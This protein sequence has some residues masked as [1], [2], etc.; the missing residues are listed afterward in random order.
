MAAS[1]LLFFII[2]Q[3]CSSDEREEV[4]VEEIIGREGRSDAPVWRVRRPVE[5]R[6]LKRDGP[7]PDTTLAIQEWIIG[8]GEDAITVQIHSFPA[9]SPE[10]RIPPMAQITRWQKQFSHAPRPEIELVRQAFSGYAGYL[11]D[12]RGVLKGEHVRVLGFAMSLPERSF[13]ALSTL[14]GKTASEAAEMRSDITIKVV[15]REEAVDKREREIRTF[16]RSFELI[17]PIP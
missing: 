2:L 16:A 17:E 12:G 8:E 15:G 4:A 9:D 6:S 7:Q 1:L 13:A 10:R 3:G 11:M 5:W 14:K